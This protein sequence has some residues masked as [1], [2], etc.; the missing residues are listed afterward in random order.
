MLKSND[1]L[2]DPKIVICLNQFRNPVQMCP[3]SYLAL[4]VRFRAG[5]GTR[6]E[7]VFSMILNMLDFEKACFDMFVCSDFG[8]SM[9]KS[10][11]S[12][13]DLK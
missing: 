9:L 11:D 4:L 8:T 12:L 2:G 7:V 1:F 13:G 10:S 6:C 5:F 3:Y